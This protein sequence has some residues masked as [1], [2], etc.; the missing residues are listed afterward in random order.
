MDRDDF[1]YELSPD[2]ILHARPC[3]SKAGENDLALALPI[4]QSGDERLRIGCI[5]GS[6]FDIDRYQ[7]NFPICRDAGV[8][9]GFDYL[10]IGDTHSFRDVTADSP[11][12]PYILA[13]PNPRTSA[14]PVLVTSH[15][16]HYSGEDGVHASIPSQSRF[17]AG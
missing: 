12:P 7:T 4:R 5:H 3:R 11:V 1:K 8:Q 9:R 2:V 15:L 13:L 6:T 16:S 10:A 17:G 14:S